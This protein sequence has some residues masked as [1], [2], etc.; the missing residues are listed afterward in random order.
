LVLAW[1]RRPTRRETHIRWYK[2]RR[3]LHRV[4][5]ADY[6]PSIVGMPCC[7][8]VRREP[9][10]QNK[11]PQQWRSFTSENLPVKAKIVDRLERSAVSQAS[12]LGMSDNQIR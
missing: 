1:W 2:I 9:I 3:A 5:P 12:L 6:L 10:P 4:V 8:P 7:A 11:Q